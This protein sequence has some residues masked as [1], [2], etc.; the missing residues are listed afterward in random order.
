MKTSERQMTIIPTCTVTPARL[1]VFQAS[2]R[3][4]MLAEPGQW[5]ETPWGRCRVFGRLGQRHADVYEAARWCAEETR[6]RIDG[7]TSILVDPA[8]LRRALGRD[9][10]EYSHEQLWLLLSEI[11][12]A[13]VEIRATKPKKFNALGHFIDNVRDSEN[14]YRPDPLTGR[15]RPMWV[16][17]LGDVAAVLDQHDLPLHYD[18]RPI[19]ALQSGI[20]QAL[21]RHLMTHSPSRQPNGGWEL[22]RLITSVAGGLE[23]DNLRNA[24]RHVRRDADALAEMGIVINGDRVTR[25]GSVTQP[26]DGV[27][28]PPGKT[29]KR[30]TPARQN[31][32]S[33]GLS[34]SLGA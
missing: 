5:Q 21:A 16:I 4:L 17:R 24:R 12:S 18:P 1:G 11:M 25:A 7:C 6:L 22:D 9:G 29:A 10:S 27:T 26:P 2:Q 23:S 13:V 30:D 19:A 8:R 31:G 20:S 15:P 33:L 34:G 3:P 32:V 14:H 28:Q